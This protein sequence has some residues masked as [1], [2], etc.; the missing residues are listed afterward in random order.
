MAPF[1]PLALVLLSA[2]GGLAETPARPSE[3]D[4]AAPT[5]DAAGPAQPPPATVAPLDAGPS[6]CVAAGGT[7]IDPIPCDGILV[8]LACGPNTSCCMPVTWDGGICPPTTPT[9]GTPCDL[10]SYRACGYAPCHDAICGAADAGTWWVGP[11]CSPP[12]PG[13]PKK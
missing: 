8:G 1:R 2:C 4:A 5:V 11:D 10:P 13:G 7:C 6:A 12:P 3:K 9:P